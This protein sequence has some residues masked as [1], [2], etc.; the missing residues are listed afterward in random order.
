MNKQNFSL[1][2]QI[3][4]DGG[5]HVLYFYSDR[6]DY[7]TNAAA[8]L[9][10]GLKLGQHTLLI[11]AEDRYRDILSLLREKLEPPLLDRLLYTNR[12]S[13]YCGCGRFDPGR[14]SERVSEVLEPIL[15]VGGTIRTWGNVV[16]ESDGEDYFDRLEQH[17]RNSDRTVRELGSLS[18]CAYDAKRVP[19]HLQNEMLRTH[20][21]FMTDATLTKS[22]LYEKQERTFPSLS[23][24][25]RMQSEVEFYKQ[26][27]EFVNVISH[28]VRNPLTVINA[29]ASML[30]N[31]PLDAESRRKLEAIID[32]VKVIDSEIGFL[33][34]TEQMLSSDALWK[35]GP[36]EVKPVLEEVSAAMATKA[37]TQNVGFDSRIELDDARIVGNRIGLRLL[38]SNMISNAIKYSDEGRS[39]KLEA[40]IREGRLRIVVTDEGVGMTPEQVDK[41]YR[42][43]H[44]WRGEARGQGTGL[45]MVL[46]LAD[47]FSGAVS[48]ETEAGR[49]T[50]IIV[51]LPLFSDGA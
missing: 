31:Q 49:G 8:F 30:A 5:A 13:V 44:K 43:F 15:D 18:V 12:A 29:Y 50:A 19:A 25:Q 51:T 33:I 27:L 6:T 9:E 37:R 23:I 16:W 48:I 22:M 40:A 36:L 39:V 17:E 4:T 42:T 47:H 14:V 24:H 20:E 32:Y 34:H 28:E 1:T 46:Q 38:V 45:Y 10:A 21:Y 35:N 11:D 7:V 2:E 3:E 41:L 26:K